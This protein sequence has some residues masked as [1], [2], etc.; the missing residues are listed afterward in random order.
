MLSEFIPE[1]NYLRRMA[2]GTIKQVNPFTGTEVWTVPGRAHR[3]LAPSPD[4]RPLSSPGGVAGCAFCPGHYFETPP[5]KARLVATADGYQTLRFLPAEELER[6][7]AEFRR[8]PNLFEILSFAYWNQNFGYDIPEEVQAR[9]HAYLSSER[10][11]VHVFEVLRKR[12]LATGMARADIDRLSEAELVQLANAFFAGAHELVVTHRHFVDGATHDDQ[13]ASSGTLSPEEHYQYLRFTIEALRDI[14]LGNRYVRYVAVFQN[15][16]RAAGASVDHLHKQLVAIDE[17]GVQNERELRL[18]RANPNIY[19]E[20]A[21]NFAGYRNLVFAENHHAIAFAGF[22]H[23]F[24]TLEIFS[25][26]QRSQPWNHTPAELRAVSDLVHACHAAMGAHIPCNEEWHY[27]PPDADVS[28]PW[29]VLISWRVNTPAG[30]EGGTHIYVNTIDPESLRD[31]VVPRLYAL[32]EQGRIAPIQIAT[33][34]NCEPNCL[35][36]N[37]AVRRQ[38]ARDPEFPPLSRRPLRPGDEA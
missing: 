27:K 5:E 14:Y 6:S 12:L 32:R 21:V 26:S 1:S 9:K 31:R 37:P 33:E 38:S 19:N 13:L 23:R 15:W 10:G 25:K 17:R 20:A 22:G 4:A 8:L 3:P 28:M 35:Q 18:V 16:L 34:C 7:V 36:Y 29:R 24:P 11:R 30:F 2:D